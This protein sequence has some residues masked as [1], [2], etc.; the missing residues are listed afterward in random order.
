M[1]QKQ[2]E[3]AAAILEKTFAGIERKLSAARGIV[4]IMQIDVCDGDFVPSKTY[5]SSAREAS[6]VR[7]ARA[8]KKDI[9]ELDMMVHWD[10]PIKNR[11]ERWL[12]AIK[13]AKPDYVVLHYDSTQHWNAIFDYFKK[14]DI[15][16]G[17]GVH[18]DHSNKDIYALL[19]KY[20]F[21]YVQV[22]GIEKVG[23]GGQGFS[24]KTYTKVRALRARFPKLPI[25]ID[26]SVKVANAEKLI[27]AG[28][29]RLASGSGIFKYKDGVKEAVRLMRAA[30]K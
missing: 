1:Q 21:S 24:S 27:N 30:G 6:F 14:S 9:L 15:Q 11:F 13:S 25:S 18:L 19:E 28:A 5:G 17:L 23:F 20:P 26:G 3:I 22:M 29:T 2:V 12:N 4:D 7:I 16:F 10:A 8:T